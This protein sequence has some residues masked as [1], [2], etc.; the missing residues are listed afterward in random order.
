MNLT[1]YA[2][3]LSYLA[4]LINTQTVR[5]M[6]AY[7]LERMKQLLEKLGN[8]QDSYPVIHI[9]GTSGK[10]STATICSHLL[11][12]HDYKTGLHVSPHLIDFRERIQIDNHYIDMDTFVTACQTVFPFVESMRESVRWLPSY[13]EASM[14]VVILCFALKQVDVA[15]IEVGC[16]WLYDGSN[17]ISRSDKISV[18]TALGYDHTDILGQTIEEIAFQKAWIILP[19]TTCISFVHPQPSCRQI[20]SDIAARQDATLIRVDPKDSFDYEISLIGAHQKTNAHIAYAAV[21][22]FLSRQDT[23]IDEAKVKK[24]LQTITLPG[25]CHHLHLQWK[26]ILLDGAHNEQKMLSLI[27]TLQQHFPEKKYHFYLAFKEGKDRQTMLDM[28]LPH[29]STIIIGEFEGIQDTPFHSV[30]A[31]MIKTYIESKNDTI[32]ISLSTPETFLADHLVSYDQNDI[33]VCTWSL[34]RLSDLYKSRHI[35]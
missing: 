33:I 13:Y 24:T 29:A 11:T 10:W 1:T 3:C 34:Y 6:G 28:I 14:A 15:V 2:D 27:E 19:Q 18:I 26:D 31:M 35:H 25:R 21:E 4:S 7:G 12:A 5:H 20:I 32:A 8:P 30:D 16:G 22:L 17:S 23:A 9:A